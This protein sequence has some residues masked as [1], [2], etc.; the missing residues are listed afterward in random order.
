MPACDVPAH[1]VAKDD[2]PEHNLAEDKLAADKLAECAMGEDGV[3][4]DGVAE[5]G[6]AVTP[7]GGSQ[8]AS[9]QAGLAARLGWEVHDWELVSKAFAHRS[10]CAEHAGQEPNERL[11]FLG[12]AV[13]GVIVTDHLYRSYPGLPEGELAKARAA[14]VNSTS[15][16]AVARDL[17]LGDALLLGKGEDSSGGRSKLSILADAMEALIGAI[18]LD[19]GYTVA[20]KV[21]LELLAG[22]VCEAASGPGGEDYKTAPPGAVRAELR[23]AAHLQ[24]Q[25]PWARS[26]QGLRRRGVRR[27]PQEGERGRAFQEAGRT[28]GCTPRLASATG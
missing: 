8:P 19:A 21:V 18:Y 7:D 28:G 4:E 27:R 9:E 20:R 26:R 17:R 5:D 24:G 25:R 6:V 23:R 22:R 11:E 10:W 12:D 1:D 3:A 16:A 2:V 14:V 13:L 15:L